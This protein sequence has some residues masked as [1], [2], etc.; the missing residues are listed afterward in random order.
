MALQLEHIKQE[1]EH[2]FIKKRQKN[3]RKNNNVERLVLCQ[4]NLKDQHL[5][6][7]EVG[8]EEKEDEIIYNYIIIFIIFIISKDVCLNI[9][10]QLISLHNIV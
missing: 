8:V 10:Y 1:R 3:K 2:L 4:L 9:K 5:D 6:H 7:N